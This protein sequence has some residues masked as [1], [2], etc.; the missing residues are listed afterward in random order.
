MLNGIIDLV[1]KFANNI[2]DQLKNTDNFHV[3]LWLNTHTFM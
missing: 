2:C 1:P 3:A